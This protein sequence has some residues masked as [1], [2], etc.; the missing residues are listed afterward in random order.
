MG[1]GF[2]ML[3]Y[4]SPM[5]REWLGQWN[6]L[7]IDLRPR[8]WI[9]NCFPKRFWLNFGDPAD[10]F[11][12]QAE[13]TKGDLALPSSAKLNDLPGTKQH[14]IAQLG[15]EK[16]GSVR[17]VP[18]LVPSHGGLHRGAPTPLIPVVPPRTGWI[19]RETHD[20]MVKTR[21]FP[22]ILPSIPMTPYISWYILIFYIPC[23]IQ[24]L[25]V[26]SHM[27]YILLLSLTSSR[28]VS[29]TALDA[30]SDFL[31]DLAL[32]KWQNWRRKLW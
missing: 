1:F 4:F 22:V 8:R 21:G 13:G 24:F 27:N 16:P 23:K 25:M 17:G 30:Q 19:C 28:Q 7:A 31:G 3:L 6:G 18:E 5:W 2:G 11:T 12:S 29:G 14:S 26:K 20:L 15:P 9:R 32:R 10:I